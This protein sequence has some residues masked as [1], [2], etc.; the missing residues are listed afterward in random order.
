MIMQDFEE[1]IAFETSDPKG[2]SS[3]KHSCNDNE[4]NDE[5]TNNANNHHN[6][7]SSDITYSNTEDDINTGHVSTGCNFNDSNSNNISID[8]ALENTIMVREDSIITMVMI[9]ILASRRIRMLR[10]QLLLSF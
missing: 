5:N 7:D 2:K 6:R 1:A 4:N 10:K 9:L 8:T 3:T